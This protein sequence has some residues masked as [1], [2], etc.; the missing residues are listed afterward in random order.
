MDRYLWLGSLLNLDDERPDFTI[1]WPT[2][3]DSRVIGFL[4][5][6]GLQG[7]PFAIL[8]PGTIWETKHWRPEGFA[9][10]GQHLL[11]QG[12]GVIV[13][14]T[15]RER[16]RCQAVVQ[17]CP[18]AVD[19]SGQTTLAEFA[20]L[21][22]RSRI[23]ITNDSGSMHLAV[24]LDRPV[25]SIFGPT[26]PL[27]IGPYGRPDAVLQADLPCTSCYYRRLKQCPND[28][29]CMKQVTSAQVIERLESI[30]AGV[31]RRCG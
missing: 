16:P 7:R 8:V 9:E 18:G 3:A 1:Y 6:H 26:D 2:E 25:V 20:A 15:M 21:M 11:R 31:V 14:G 10:V 13:A 27:R 29:A 22:N 24:A 17:A 30:L 19:L 12:M 4:N 5:Q 28:H 23:N